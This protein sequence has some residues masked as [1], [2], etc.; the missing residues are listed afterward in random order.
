MF[1]NCPEIHY[2]DNILFLD[3]YCMASDVSAASIQQYLMSLLFS[4]HAIS[5]IGV[6]LTKVL[7]GWEFQ[8][9]LR[10]SC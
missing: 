6:L 4:V 10:C 8:F 3:V 2:L 1:S 9:V 5:A 7:F